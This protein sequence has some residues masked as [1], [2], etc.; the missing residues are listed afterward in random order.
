[1]EEEQSTNNDEVINAISKQKEEIKG[2]IQSQSEE[3][4][5]T[6]IPGTAEIDN[7]TVTQDQF[8]SKVKS[9]FEL[10]PSDPVELPKQEITVNENVVREDNDL[11]P[12]QEEE[13]RKE[14]PEINFD[15]P[16]SK[17][18]GADTSTRVKIFKKDLYNKLKERESETIISD[19]TKLEAKPNIPIEQPEQPIK[20]KPI[21]TENADIK[22]FNSDLNTPTSVEQK[23]SAEKDKS[24]KAEPVVIN[25]EEKLSPAQTKTNI[26]EIKPSVPIELP[27]QQLLVNSIPFE[28][29]KGE[30]PL[31]QSTE[32]FNNDISTPVNESS[33]DVKQPSINFENN[34]N[35]AT[36][37]QARPTVDQKRDESKSKNQPS[38][39]PTNTPE[40]EIP[41]ASPSVNTNLPA[42]DQ[43]SQQPL[44]TTNFSENSLDELNKNIVGLTGSVNNIL[45]LL[46]NA[47]NIL[48]NIAS[49]ENNITTINNVA[50]N[51]SSSSQKQY[52]MI[53]SS[54]QAYRQTIRTPNDINDILGR[55]MTPNIP[56]AIYG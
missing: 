3:K 23:V 2:F 32:L 19:K 9:F 34:L 12:E 28:T 26:F 48:A 20:D 53:N 29:P 41:E 39:P 25:Q 6:V 42:E 37:S 30:Q 50:G 38:S 47:T 46:S 4:I 13:L 11:T 8:F 49:K 35:I 17:D 52:Q 18:E 40:Q 43:T 16:V 22:E 10:R 15:K 31:N 36:A 55:T 5:P 21:I 1:M 44:K 45:N 33:P 7:D 27:K 14:Y 56:G 51:G 54:I 24:I